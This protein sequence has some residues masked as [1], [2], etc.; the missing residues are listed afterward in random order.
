VTGYP[1]GYTSAWSVLGLGA[2]ALIVF[3]VVHHGAGSGSALAGPRVTV[4]VTVSPRAS[5]PARAPSSRA[6]PISGGGALSAGT[7]PQP[8]RRPA[9]SGAGPSSVPSAPSQSPKPG[10][11]G[12]VSAAIVVPLRGATPVAVRASVVAPSAPPFPQPS[13]AIGVTVELPGL[14]ITALP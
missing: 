12:S 7:A 11:G 3:Q 6:Q 10:T 1:R 5:Q 13:P 9:T 14:T 2:L 8:T 4:T